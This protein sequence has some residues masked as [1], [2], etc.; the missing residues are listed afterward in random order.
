MSILAPHQSWIQN[1]QENFGQIDCLV[2]NAGIMES[3]SV[4]DEKDNEEAL[5]KMWAVNV[6]DT[7]S[8]T[9]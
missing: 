3:V 2:N 1:T 6:K 4:D 8:L 9:R 5:D 7:L